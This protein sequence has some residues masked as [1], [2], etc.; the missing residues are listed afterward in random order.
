VNRAGLN[1]LR[2]V[3]PAAAGLVIAGLLSGCIVASAITMPV[4]LVATT[5]VVVGET[6]STVVTSTAKVARSA[7]TAGSSVASDG[8]DGVAKLSHAGMVTFVDAAS[9]S[10]VRVPWEQGFTLAKAKETAG[11]H[12]AKRAVDLVRA[13]KIVYSASRYGGA[14][15]PLADGDVVRAK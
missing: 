8:L 9:G 12:V 14:E 2:A 5:V 13:G 3:A 11:M 7:M 6:A 10:V 15:I 4:K 1:A